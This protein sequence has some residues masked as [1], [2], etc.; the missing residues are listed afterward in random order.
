MAQAPIFEPPYNFNDETTV[1]PAQLQETI[2]EAS[3]TINQIR[4]NLAIIQRDDT[5]LGD[6]IVDVRSLTPDLLALIGNYNNRGVWATA[7]SYVYGDLFVDSQ[8]LYLTILDHTSTTIEA[9]LLANKLAL[10]SRDFLNQDR[11]I[12]NVTATGTANTYVL[13]TNEA[14]PYEDGEQW[15]VVFPASNTAASTLNRDGLGAK[16]IKL[17]GAD[18]PNNVLRANQAYIIRYNAAIDA[19]EMAQSASQNLS[20]ASV[21]GMEIDVSDNLGAE[22]NFNSAIVVD[23]NGFAA[24]IGSVILSGQ[25]DTFRPSGTTFTLGTIYPVMLLWSEQDGHVVHLATSTEADALTQYTHRARIGFFDTSF[26]TDPNAQF[27]TRQRGFSLRGNVIYYRDPI[28][29]IDT[30]TLRAAGSTIVYSGIQTSATPIF[31]AKAYLGSTAPTSAT[32]LLLDDPVIS[33]NGQLELLE[34]GTGK[35]MIV[36]RVVESPLRGT[37]LAFSL[38]TDPGLDYQI[39]VQIIGWRIDT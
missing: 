37:S 29:L 31:L 34:I 36:E 35:D 10:L 3:T 30:T 7:T 32:R 4:D 28:D 33:G 38:E 27:G 16:S 13:T 12:T 21:S 5:K 23:E 8:N 6:G 14:D 15:Y 17:G 18:L 26:V 25:P 1:V 22:I 19:F 11:G 39:T 24:R 2:M 20:I 9:D